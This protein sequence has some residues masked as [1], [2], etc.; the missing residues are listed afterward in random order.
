MKT[1]VIHFDFDQKRTLQSI[2]AISKLSKNPI[3]LYRVI[4]ILYLA[5]RK[6]LI[7]TGQTITGAP[8]WNFNHISKIPMAE[9]VVLKSTTFTNG[10]MD[11]PGDGE[12][13]DYNFSLFEEC[14]LIS[15]PEYPECIDYNKIVQISYEDI[16]KAHGVSYEVIDEYFLNNLHTNNIRKY[17]KNES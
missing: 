3:T 16:L 17:F 7:E 1:Q 11:N 2:Y 13:S 8:V 6:S 9:S 10:K 12:L 14:S 15:K 4:E 5:D